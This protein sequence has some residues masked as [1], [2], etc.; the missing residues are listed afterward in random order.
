MSRSPLWIALSIVVVS[1]LLAVILIWLNIVPFPSSLELLASSDQDQIPIAEEVEIL[2]DQGD[3]VVAIPEADPNKFNIAF[4]YQETIENSSWSD[5]HDQGRRFIEEQLAETHTIAIQNI[6]TTSEATKVIRSLAQNGYQA[7]F[8]TSE[9]YA[10]QTASV[11][12]EFADIAFININGHQLNELNLGNVSGAMED[13]KY[14]AGM[15]AGARAAE[16]ASFLVG[17]LAAEPT[18]REIRLSNAAVLGMQEVCPKCVADIRW[19]FGSTDPEDQRQAID[20]LFEAGAGVIVSHLSS[21]TLTAFAHEYGIRIL[22]SDSETAC[23]KYTEACLG[24]TYWNWGPVYVDIVER[25]MAGT[26]EPS[27]FYGTV[28]D[29]M[30]GFTGFM[31]GETPSSG[32]PEWVI[33]LVTTTLSKMQEGT[34]TRHTIFGG[35]LR[36]NY[37][38]VRSSGVQLTQSD[39]E[40]L[41]TEY[42]E[43][44]EITHRDPCQ[45]CMDFLVQGFVSDPL[46]PEIPENRRQIVDFWTTESN[47]EKQFI[48]DELASQ[49]MVQNQHV[50]IEIQYID[51][52]EFFD[53]FSQASELFAVPDLV[54]ADVKHLRGLIDARMLDMDA[55]EEVIAG[56]GA[57]DFFTGTLAL[58]TDDVTHYY[59]A[60][61]FTG[62]M[63]TLWYR[64]D[65]F[66]TFGLAPPSTWSSLTDAAE[67]LFGIG[68]IQQG[69]A[70][71]LDPTSIY[72]HQIFEQLAI[73]EGIYPFDL[74]GNVTMNSPEMIALLERYSRLFTN[75]FFGEMDRRDVLEAYANGEV[76]MIF[77]DLSL[78]Q[79]AGD[80][81][82][83]TLP[84][85]SGTEEAE[86]GTAEEE[87]NSIDG[88]ESGGTDL[89]QS[90]SNEADDA[91]LSP[92]VVNTDV[93]N[94]ESIDQE[95]LEA[96]SEQVDPEVELQF[97]LE[98]LGFGSSL[99]PSFD[100]SVNRSTYGALNILAI[101]RTADPT[102]QDF[103]EFLMT[104]GYEEFIATDPLNTM[105]VHSLGQK[106]WLFSHELIQY[107]DPDALSRLNDSYS[108]LMRWAYHPAYSQTQRA[109]IDEIEHQRL[110]PDVV[111]R[112]AFEGSMTPE[113]GAE[114]LQTNVEALWSEL[115]EADR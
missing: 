43:E 69:V 58:I 10:E 99:V 96:E 68:Q 82:I 114:F 102:A 51:D 44:Q 3:L 32:T 113:E 63:Q 21:P 20:E 90:D 115:S 6:P 18:P 77:Y 62:W 29:N 37:D 61:P 74:K 101:T 64:I 52:S 39:F 98:E 50:Q 12:E 16:N 17:V 46:P 30:M 42:L 65:H 19:T 34:L 26:W 73:A 11:A 38:Q 97:L 112:T 91:D 75:D 45:L 71:G 33:P 104:D 110:I 24:V 1:S 84:E 31:E 107:Y 57:Q 89:N 59:T 25:V 8:T 56:I 48:L 108:T 40:G 87:Q 2:T 70:V 23:Q 81:Y 22:V 55:A 67:N 93:A 80:Y 83:G 14:L 15:V 36:D 76:G 72:T 100:G 4:V 60:V 109:V 78:L 53:E 105:P 86:S 94:T 5:A 54:Y 103:A 66:D 28:Q 35:I 79:D 27:D 47:P 7:I 41:T 85:I 88:V 95:N 13:M 106:E 92:N 9:K 49:Y 111:Y